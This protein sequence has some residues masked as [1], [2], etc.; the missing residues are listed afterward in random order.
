MIFPNLRKIFLDFVKKV[1]DIP[2]RLWYS[3]Q[4]LT[5]RGAVPDCSFWGVYLVN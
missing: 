4:A 2:G 3:S 5:P 1:L